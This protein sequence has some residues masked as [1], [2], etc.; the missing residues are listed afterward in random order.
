MLVE[1]TELPEANP[2]H[3][4]LEDKREIIV[5]LQ[6][7]APVPTFPQAE[8]HV[9]EDEANIL[10]KPCYHVDI[11]VQVS[12]T[13]A[14]KSAKNFVDDSH[15]DVSYQKIDVATNSPAD[16]QF[17]RSS[18]ALRRPVRFGSNICS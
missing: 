8:K 7:L 1:K 16:L 15:Y 3:L 9:A 17:R 12:Q 11:N 2:H 5:F 6:D 18:L 10:S 13:N 14:D 4:R